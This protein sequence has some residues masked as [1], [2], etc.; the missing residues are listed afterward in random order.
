MVL[1]AFVGG[2]AGEVADPEVPGVL[3][4][5][6]ALGT[7]P[8]TASMVMRCRIS[9]WLI[10]KICEVRMCRSRSSWSGIDVGEARV[11]PADEFHQ[12]QPGGREQVGEGLVGSV[13]MPGFSASSV[14]TIIF[15]TGFGVNTSEVFCC[16]M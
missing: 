1:L 4:P 10:S 14:S 9:L 5:G 12:E 6:L 7:P 8:E 13:K 16:G 11:E 2:H 15:T 3:D